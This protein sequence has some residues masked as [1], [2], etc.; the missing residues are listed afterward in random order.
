MIFFLNNTPAPNQIEGSP[1]PRYLGRT[2]KIKIPGSQNLPLTK[3][4]RNKMIKARQDRQ[5]KVLLSKQ[6]SK[7]D[8]KIGNKVRIFNSYSNLWDIT[9]ETIQEIP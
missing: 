6:T 3:E 2:P 8:F 1:S 4:D 5:T 7:P 9:G